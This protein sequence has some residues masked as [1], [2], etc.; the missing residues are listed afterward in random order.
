A[1]Q[2]GATAL[3]DRRNGQKGLFEGADDAQAAPRPKLPDMPEWEDRE[4]LANEK[5]VLGFYLSSHPLAEVQETLDTFCTH[6]TTA[7][8]GLPNRSDVLLGGVL[9]S[10]TF[11][12]SKNAR[13]GAPTKY[14]MWDLEDMSGIMRCIL[15]ADDYLR[16][17]QLVEADRVLAVRGV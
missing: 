11:K 7:A 9:A 8:A 15:W 12:H 6:T 5:Q 1:L 14:A 13:P 2:S 4:R 3:A 16:L 10:V 17:G